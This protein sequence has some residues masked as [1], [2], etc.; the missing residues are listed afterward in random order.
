MYKRQ[1]LRGYNKSLRWA[2]A[3]PRLILATF[4][5]SLILTIVMFATV[6][7]DF[8]P[9]GDSGRLLAFTEGAQD[10]SFASMVEHQ[11]AVAEIVAK[12]ANIRSFMS[13]VGA[14][15]IRPTSNTCLL[16]T[17]RCV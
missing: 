10:A 6:P 1:L 14:G 4:F 8:I 12:D 9:S 11:R 5:I 17:S 16:Y 13:S 3:R 15:G 2:M 7:K